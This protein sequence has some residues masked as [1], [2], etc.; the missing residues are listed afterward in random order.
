[1]KYFCFT[2]FF[3][4]F[5]ALLMGYLSI[6]RAVCIYS[7]TEKGDVSKGDSHLRDS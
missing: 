5:F 7:C 6:L 3:F 4:F 2:S 1:M